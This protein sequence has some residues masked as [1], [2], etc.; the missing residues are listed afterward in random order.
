MKKL[1]AQPS[2]AK[3]IAKNDQPTCGK[4]LAENSRLPAKLGWLMA[5]LAGNLELHMKTLDLKDEN[6]MQEHEAYH[7]LAL[8]QREIAN[9]L[10]ATSGDM[11]GYRELPM[12]KH[13]EKKLRD[14]KIRQAFER[15]VNLKK[16]LA[17]L[18]QKEIKQD[19]EL[20]MQM[21]NN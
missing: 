5:S 15:F 10:M 6:A 8:V 1:F 19:Q 4:G 20:L 12:A 3:K 16:E 9:L 2:P 14:P 18:L 17:E 13:D 21:Q 11:L 7:K